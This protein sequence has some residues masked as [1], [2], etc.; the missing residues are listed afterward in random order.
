MKNK[1]IPFYFPQ[2]HRIPENDRWWGEGYTDWDR[3]KNALPLS[4]SHYQPRIP[5]DG[6]YYSQDNEETLK[7]QIELAISNNIYGF[8]FYHY[9]FDGKLLLQKP[10]EIFK[11]L[12]HDLKFCITWANETWTKRWEGKFNE[13]LIKQN[14]KYD[15][16]E[17]KKHFEYLSIFFEDERYIKIDGKPVFMLYRPDIFPKVD[18]FIAFFQDLAIKRGMKGIY[19]VGIK[20]YEVL[21]KSIYESF[22]ALLKFQPRELFGTSLK[23]ESSTFKAIEK[24]LRHLPERQQIWLGDLRQKFAGSTSY[25]IDEFWK[26]LIKNA[27]AD[28]SSPKKIFQSILPDWDNTAR[29]GKKAKYFSNSSPEKF[30]FYLKEL[31]EVEKASSNDDVLIFINA[32]NEWSEGA[33]LEPDIRNEYRYLEILKKLSDF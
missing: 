18:Q 2:L 9:W 30:E 16:D 33:Y 13:V 14:H 7:N 12:S 26:A 28:Q 17:W 6:Q 10:I 29:Y 4:G 22:D 32:W 31:I 20:A 3:V 5:L 15:V 27:L 21:D 23:R 1:F 24:I 8:N 11:N 19:F 25:N